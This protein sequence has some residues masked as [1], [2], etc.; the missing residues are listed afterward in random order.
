M[1]LVKLNVLKSYAKAVALS[2]L[3][4]V[5]TISEVSAGPV[6]PVNGTSVINM[7][8]S[9]AVVLALIFLFAFIA[10]KLRIGP[11]NQQ[12]IKLV[13]NLTIGQKERVVVVEVENEQ[14]LLGVTST[15]IN[16]LQKLPQNL[17]EAPQPLA[18]EQLPFDL[19]SVLKKGKS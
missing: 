10:K 14:Y 4:I 5:L 19:M 2:F 15:Q 8:M 6:T 18:T 9:L 17:S 13:A 11:A 7:L 3:S 12:G 16:L 1:L